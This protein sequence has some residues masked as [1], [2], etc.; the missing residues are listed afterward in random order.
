MTATFP[1]VVR[2]L[3]HA[4]LASTDAETTRVLLQ[5]F[6][7]RGAEL[8]VGVD[9]GQPETQLVGEVMTRAPGTVTLYERRGPE[10]FEA[11]ARTGQRLTTAF[12][13]G[14]GVL[15]TQSR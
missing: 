3:S 4:H 8:L 5:R 1:L 13:A 11:R 6:P 12:R 7:L 9:D 2:R 10:I 14:C 15:R